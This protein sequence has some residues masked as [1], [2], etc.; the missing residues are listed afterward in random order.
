MNYSKDKERKKSSP[1]RTTKDESSG[2]LSQSTFSASNSPGV[3]QTASKKTVQQ[4]SQKCQ[5][6]VLKD[7]NKV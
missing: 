2:S 7:K 6:V 4:R 3:S 1:G 5:G